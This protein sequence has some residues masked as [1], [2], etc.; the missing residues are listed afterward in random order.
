MN[1]HNN[2]KFNSLPKQ[3]FIYFAVFGCLFIWIAKFFGVPQIIVTLVA[4]ALIPLYCY[5]ALRNKM[6]FIKE[7]QIG[8]NAYYMGFLF[9]LTS[10]SF[11]LFTLQLGGVEG[12]ETA[13]Q[14][15]KIV[16]NFGV[17]L[18]ST[19]AGIACRIYIA[20]LRQDISEIEEDVKIKLLETANDVS[21][22]LHNVLYDFNVFTT[23]LKNSIQEN[24]EVVNQQIQNNLLK[25]S[26]NFANELNKNMAEGKKIIEHFHHNAD[27]INKESMAVY[28]AFKNMVLKIESTDMPTKIFTQ[29][30]DE[31]F[32][33]INETVSDSNEI[34]QQQ[35]SVNMENIRQMQ[36]LKASF[37]NL[38][39]AIENCGLEVEKLRTKKDSNYN[40]VLT[41]VNEIQQGLIDFKNISQKHSSLVLDV[42]NKNGLMINES[43]KSN[44]IISNADDNSKFNIINNSL[45]EIIKNLQ[46]L[47]TDKNENVGFFNKFINK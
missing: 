9:T 39:I 2:H 47:K 38:K 43:L 18:W 6:F 8:D 14:V 36:D 32:I 46:E 7:D 34:C 11:A 26:E 44:D 42:I 12:N 13:K 27:Q 16:G 1:N 19:I 22:N 25:I 28:G 30:I 17:A 29:K 41:T 24:Y 35:N 10:L 21:C 20:Q 40:Q 4:V 23:S 37:N 33:K 31:L 45:N 3:L 5:I 15:S